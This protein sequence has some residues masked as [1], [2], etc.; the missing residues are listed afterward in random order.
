M[1][2]LVILI[3][4]V[5]VVGGFLL[6]NSLF[7]VRENQQVL[8]LQFGQFVRTVNEGTTEE[9]GLHAKLP[10]VQDTI[11]YDKR[12]LN[13]D[14]EGSEVLL[15][16]QERLVVDAFAR[17]RII[18]PRLFFQTVGTTRIAEQRLTPWLEA[19]LRNALGRASQEDVLYQRRIE[20]MEEIGNELRSRAA[21]LGLEVI[22]VRIRAADL[23]QEIQTNV[24]QR[25]ITDRQQEAA[26]TRAEG[27]EQYRRITSQ[28]DAQVT[29]LLAEAER[30]AQKLRGEGDQQAISIYAEAF[31]RDPDFYAFYRSLEAYRASLTSDTTL[32]LS[33]QSEFF[34]FFGSLSGTFSASE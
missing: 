17:Y 20:L 7:I 34:R 22:D 29:I 12:I 11:Y 31:S 26:K 4:I 10:F 16:N 14:P 5:L 21:A 28:A 32:V 1:N 3:G 15:R 2:R 33:P 9:P 23:P 19:S 13:L 25:M 30:D 18:D 6:A 8:V 27:E 24:F